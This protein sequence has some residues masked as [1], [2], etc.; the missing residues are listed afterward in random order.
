MRNRLIRTITAVSYLNEHQ[1]AELA[2]IASEL[3][4]DVN[5]NA[6]IVS[7]IRTDKASQRFAIVESA[8]R[9][10]AKIKGLT[11][12]SIVEAELAEMLPHDASIRAEAE[13][14]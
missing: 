3:P 11:A 8:A 1:K 7:H 14:R 2:E 4:L 5:V 10:E 12:Q 9:E 6:N 13:L